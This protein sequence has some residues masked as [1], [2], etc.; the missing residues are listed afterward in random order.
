MHFEYAEQPSSD[1]LAQAF[2]IGGSLLAMILPAWYLV[3]IFFMDLVLQLF[4]SQ[5]SRRCE[6]NGKASVF[7][8]WV[9]DPERY[10]VAEFDRQGN[11][12]RY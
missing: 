11:C 2:I 8:Y 6:V 5:G 7:G 4:A 3:I 1:G 10:G 12:L 9:S